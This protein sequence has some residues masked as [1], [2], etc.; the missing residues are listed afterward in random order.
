MVVMV[1]S[2]VAM[3][4]I[5]NSQSASGGNCEGKLF[6]NSYDCS[7]KDNNTPPFNDCFEFGTLHISQFFDLG[8]D[9]AAWG[10]ACDATGSNSP[11]FNSSSSAFE[12][13]DDE[14]PFLVNGKIKGKKLSVQGIG[15]DGE[16]FIGTC[17]LRSSP[18]F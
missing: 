14:A 7:F 3:V 18:C 12:C 5:A 10:C 15:A 11:S 17:T 16:Q 1:F 2:A 9:A 6:G 13:S 4:L 8:S